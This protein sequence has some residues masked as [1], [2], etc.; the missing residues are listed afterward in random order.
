MVDELKKEYQKQL[1]D[2]SRKTEELGK[3]EQALK[4]KENEINKKATEINQK[5]RQNT[6]KERSINEQEYQFYCKVLGSRHC[7]EAYVKEM[8]KDFWEDNLNNAFLV[9]N[10][11]GKSEHEIKQIVS[12]AMVSIYED[13]ELYDKAYDFLVEQ[14]TGYSWLNMHTV[15]NIVKKVGYCD[16]LKSALYERLVKNDLDWKGGSFREFLCSASAF[17]TYG[18]Q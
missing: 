13:L 9:G 11:V 15:Q 14:A 17:S 7:K 16:R 4:D 12:Y 5:D 2:I 8:G 18:Q 1:V 3:K 6:T 10:K